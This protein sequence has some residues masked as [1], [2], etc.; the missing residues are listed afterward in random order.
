MIGGGV[1]RL[2]YDRQSARARPRAAAIAPSMAPAPGW[3]TRSRRASARSSRATY[4]YRDYD[5]DE[6]QST[7]T[8]S[9]GPTRAIASAVGTTVD[10]TSLVFGEMSVGYSARNYD[11]SQ[12]KD[13]N[14]FGANGSLTWNVT[15][16]TSIILNAEQ[17]DPGD[18]RHGRRASTASGDLQNSVGLDVTHELLRNVLLNANAGYTRDDFQGVDAHRQHLQCRRRRQLPDQPQSFRST[19]PTSSPPAIRTLTA[20]SSPATSCWSASRPSSDRG[21][22]RYSGVVP[23]PCSQPVIPLLEGPIR[24]DP[25]GPGAASGAAQSAET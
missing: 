2:N 17:R 5:E 19:P 10:I 20:T 9:T 25:R 21:A 15:P 1:E 22:E 12:F 6:V 7:A 8:T 4:S 14:G 3:A 11:S 18:H 16:L 24:R 13:S 23:F